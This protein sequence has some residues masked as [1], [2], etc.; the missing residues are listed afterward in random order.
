ML[1]PFVMFFP[2]PTDIPDNQRYSSVPLPAALRSVPS[3][4]VP[5]LPVSVPLFPDSVPFFL[6][7]VP[8]GTEG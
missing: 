7:S 3:L 1:S 4:P 8:G 6:D 5:V 2:F